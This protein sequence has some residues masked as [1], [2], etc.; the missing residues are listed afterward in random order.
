[1]NEADKIVKEGEVVK[2]PCAV[3]GVPTPSVR[4]FVNGLD[5]SSSTTSKYKIY[6]D[7]TLRYIF[8][9]E[10]DEQDDHLL[11]SVSHNCNVMYCTALRSSALTSAAVA[12]I[13]YLFYFFD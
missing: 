10:K 9:I 13:S 12:I 3:D 11:L 4:W 2:L 1:M 7:H 6:R 5:V 8:C